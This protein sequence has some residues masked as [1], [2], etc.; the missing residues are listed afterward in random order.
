MMTSSSGCLPF[1]LHFGERIPERPG[2]PCRY[3]ARQSVSQVFSAGEWL[4]ALDMQQA[5]TAG[6]TRRTDVGRETTD[7]E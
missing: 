2:T 4:D 3:D 5:E 1:L 6:V 7:D